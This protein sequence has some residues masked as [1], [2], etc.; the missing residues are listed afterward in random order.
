[1]A[2]GFPPNVLPWVPTVIPADAFFVN[3]QAPSGNPPPIPLAIG[4]MSGI[5]QD[6][7]KAKKL[8]VLYALCTS[9]K[10]KSTLFSSHNFLK[11]LR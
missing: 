8:P 2:K 6:F 4:T 10:I 3:K 9:S 11:S 5:I 7:S 1:M